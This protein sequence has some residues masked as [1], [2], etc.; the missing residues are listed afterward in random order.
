MNGALDSSLYLKRQDEMVTG[1]L[2]KNRNGSTDEKLAFAI[3]TIPLGE[4]EDGDT[5]TTALCRELDAADIPEKEAKLSRGERGVIQHFNDLE[6]E[7]GV[8]EDDLRRAC[9]D[10]RNVSSSDK[11]DS[12]RKT[13]DN[14][15]R[16]LTEK[17]VLV[18]DGGFY[19]TP[20]AEDNLPE[21]LL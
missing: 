16:G 10:G 2:T 12:R 20:S 18:F 21:E 7:G 17:G 4:D 19:S 3:A 9:I 14:A 5:I 11:E 15:L 1:K 6:N 8:S 13:L